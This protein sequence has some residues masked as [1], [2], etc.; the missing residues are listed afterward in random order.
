MK[1]LYLT[2]SLMMIPL[3][4]HAHHPLAGQP[5]ES[6]SQG[7]LSGIGHPILGFDHLFFVLLLGVVALQSTARV[8]SIFGYLIAMLIGSMMMAF[9]LALPLIE[10]MII[11]SLICL[12][13]VALSAKYLSRAK[14]VGFF[15]LAGLF[16]G[17][18]FG[19]SIAAQ[20][21]GFST[22]ILMGYLLGLMVVQFAIA[23]AAGE[24]LKKWNDARSD[25][26]AARFMGALVLGV[27][28]FLG[29]EFAEAQVFSTLGIA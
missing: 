2:A 22:A 28:L 13:A 25:L 5:M 4:A 21:A 24:A 15:A 9:G 14:V 6:F 3:A 10:P 19:E 27:G 29:L 1:K 20:E 12:G 17:A 8:A 11:A 23:F 16:H 18:A 7:V 26:L